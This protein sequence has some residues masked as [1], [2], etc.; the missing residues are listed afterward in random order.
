MDDN[1][2]PT[3]ESPVLHL[4]VRFAE[5]DQMGIAHHSAYP[6]WMEA[7]RVQWLRAHGLDYRIMEEGG[8]SLSV[9][10]MEVE[11][12]RPAHFDDL[13]A[14]TTRLVLLRSRLMRLEYRLVRDAD[15]ALLAS[16]ATVHVPT[17]RRGR[18]MRLP[19]VWWK[20]LTALL[21][22]GS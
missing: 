19:E 15:G 10:A 7:G 21:E 18:A 11:Y 12:R 6:V 22:A 3:A 13:I 14:V 8:L 9:S 4:R 20:P 17:D 2:A 5:T 1:A 16:G